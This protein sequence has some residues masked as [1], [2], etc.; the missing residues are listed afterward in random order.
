MKNEFAAPRSKVESQ[1]AREEEEDD[2]LLDP[3]DILGRLFVDADDTPSS[4]P[5]SIP[6]SSN[7]KVE[8]YPF[9]LY[10][11]FATDAALP[12][13]RVQQQ[14]MVNPNPKEERKSKEYVEQK[15]MSVGD[16][17]SSFFASDPDAGDLRSKNTQPHNAIKGLFESILASGNNEADE[18]VKPKEVVVEAFVDMD[19]VQ[20]KVT[21][22]DSLQADVPTSSYTSSTIFADDEEDDDESVMAEQG[23]C[24]NTYKGKSCCNWRHGSTNNMLLILFITRSF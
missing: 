5:S 13:D 21:H 2:G 16:M 9:S 10:D 17:L 19:R 24:Q 18:S 23:E 8:R 22:K 11:I 7:A 20:A 3:F 15:P 6:S 12:N 1:D 14:E 4:T